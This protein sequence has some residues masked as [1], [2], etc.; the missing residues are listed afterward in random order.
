[1][2][3]QSVRI[4]LLG[5]ILVAAACCTALCDAALD[6][7]T[8][9][10]EIAAFTVEALYDNEAGSAIGARFRHARSGFVLDFL[11]I[12]TLP[13]S[14]MWVN[15][16]PT[17]DEGA[18]HT[19]EHLLLGKGT[20]GQ[21]VSS[22]EDMS[23]GNSSAFT[24]Q[25]RTCYHFNTSAGVDVFF[26]L[27]KAKLE[28]TLHP[29]YSDEEIQREVCNMG[30][31]LNPAD[32]SFELEEKGTVYAEM[33]TAFERPWGNLARDLGQLLY[34][35]KHPLSFSAGG[36]PPALRTVT[37]AGLREFHAA[38]HHL[39]NMGA[40]V[41]IPA[42]ITL[43]DF[44][45]RVGQILA[46]AEP[47]AT[48]GSHP[49][50][51]EQQLPKSAPAPIG[52]V[53]QV[54]FPHP[55]ESEPGM[56][57]FAWPAD[58]FTETR[59]RF[60]LEL[61]IA[62][63][64]S[65][66]TSNLFNKFINSEKRVID[67]GATGVFGWVDTDWG[68]P[69]FIGLSNVRREATSLEMI[70][71]LRS[72]ILAELE[73]IAAMPDGSDE[74]LAF[75]QRALNRV[76]ESRKN[77]RDMLN[78]PPR[79]GTRGTGSAWM[80]HLS[81]LHE[82]G[83][84][85][86]SLI[87]QDELEYA[88]GLLGS[89]V[90]IWREYI[91]KWRLI[92]DAPYAVATR[93]DPGLQARSEQA[94]TERIEQYAN[95]LKD[96]YGIATKQEAVDRYR[97]E[98]DARTA[99]IEAAGRSIELPPFIDNPPMTLDDQLQYTVE[100]LPGGGRLVV[101][102]FNAMTSSSI[103][104][105]FDMYVVPETQLMYLAILPSLLTDVGLFKDGRAVAYD[106]MQ[107][108][109]RREILGLH[110]YYTRNAR[111]ERVE[112]TLRAQASHTDETAKA[113]GWLND[114]LYH[115]DL[116]PAN[117]SRIRDVIDLNL[118]Q[119]RNRMKGSEESWVTIPA[120]AYWRQS[121][122]LFLNTGCFLT[123]SHALLR[124]R[125]Q[126]KEAGDQPEEF[127]Q[128]MQLLAGLAEGRQ[129]SD[130]TDILSLLAGPQ[131]TATVPAELEDAVSLMRSASETARGHMNEALKDLQLTLS[132]LPDVSLA[133]DW[134]YLCARFVSDLRVHPNDALAALS[135]V[136][137]LVRRQDNVRGFVVANEANEAII[138]PAVENIVG[139]LDTTPSRR[140]RY[141]AT[142]V[143]TSR[144][145]QR[146]GE[147]VKPLFVGLV[148]EATRSGVHINSADCAGYEDGSNQ[149]RLLNYVSSCL[150]SGGGAHS[151]F[152][153]TWAAGLAY[154]NG[155]RPNEFTGR[156]TY[157]AE[158]CPD[159]AQ[160]MQ[161]VIGELESAPY[162]PALAE[163]A[164]AQTFSRIR[165][166]TRYEIRGEVMAADLADGQTPD[167]VR[168]F[169]GKALQLREYENLGDTLYAR[170]TST[171]GTVLPGYGVS[172]RKAAAESNS[173]YFVIGPE[174][175]MQS[176]EQYLKSVEGDET[177]LYRLYP[178]D[179]WITSQSGD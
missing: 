144:L 160:T 127:T 77:L 35:E 12:Q 46:E 156:L 132:D 88:E 2:R 91:D 89:P 25:V 155:L 72:L 106:E 114:I 100:T 111:T 133:D 64:A 118:G 115:A 135:E 175:Q 47:D 36:Y 32:S 166:G 42:E 55:N 60:L 37:P 86:R 172:S 27:F 145:R 71:S 158:R 169:L 21:Y 51:F 84:F 120:T 171:Y 131:D 126:L 31:R 62:N 66:Q 8:P 109:V 119:T 58:K 50:D 28:A 9:N 104:L 122:P 139:R 69:I 137:S 125:W 76:I 24:Q 170:M 54:A 30:L 107:E 23:L 4:M 52:T 147:P 11:R 121:N 56:I 38:T 82:K 138:R 20:R 95:T 178:R 5:A 75:N 39:N 44:L 99:E 101:S 165:A 157:Y 113:T 61:L 3:R 90:N 168:N 45:T 81:R 48:A 67:V 53:R 148:N 18:P 93:P 136:L 176:Y 102:T 152:M 128:F 16:P 179:F 7:L 83:G 149:D 143:I 129:R 110:A 112:L 164:I 43:E 10:Q 70:D 1:M 108:A 41:V 74:L 80:S 73:G 153:K 26:D 34:G 65:G 79:F 6:G 13:Q 117:L 103:G 15:T 124:L 57:L 174:K 146:T 19:L 29:N 151:I 177:V 130:L 97:T 134:R 68:H 154:S 92:A 49:E 98:Y 59:E 96:K 14:F 85:R 94:R 150:Y 78:S 142:P 17:S 22:L 87:L 161:F 105:A 173:L 141:S 140:N 159:L 63:L 33:I 116:R 162:D 40:V 163:Y 123:Q 167:V